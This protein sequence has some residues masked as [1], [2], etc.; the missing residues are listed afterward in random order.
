[1]LLLRLR[2]LLVLFNLLDVNVGVCSIYLSMWVFVNSSD[3]L[4][5]PVSMSTALQ[6]T[7]IRTILE[8]NSNSFYRLH[9]IYSY[10]LRL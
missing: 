5:V 10:S 9:K 7:I 6:E 1:M 3:L 4:R 8:L 2:S